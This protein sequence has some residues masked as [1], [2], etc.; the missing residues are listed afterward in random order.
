[1]IGGNSELIH[2]CMASDWSTVCDETNLVPAAG[3]EDEVV[4]DNSNRKKTIMIGYFSAATATRKWREF[5]RQT[6]EENENWT[7]I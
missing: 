5:T 3:N 6:R 2:G 4:N 7:K 1:M